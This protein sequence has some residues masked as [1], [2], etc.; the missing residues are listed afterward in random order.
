VSAV[1]Q[2]ALRPGFGPTLITAGGYSRNSA[3]PALTTAAADPMALDRA[4]LAHPKVID[5][6]KREQAED[7]EL[8]A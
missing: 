8:I 2:A 3:E 5:R 4:W 6:M 1:F 7:L